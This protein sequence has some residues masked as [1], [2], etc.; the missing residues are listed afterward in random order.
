MNRPSCIPSQVLGTALA[1]SMGLFGCVG[2]YAPGA[3][4]EAPPSSTRVA[5]QRGCVD[6]AVTLAAEPTLPASS[7]LL[8]FTFGNRCDGLQTIDLSRVVVVGR[9]GAGDT[10]LAG[11]APRGQVHPGQL[12]AK[13]F[14]TELLRYDAPNGTAFERVC[15]DLRDVASGAD[16]TVGLQCLTPPG[17][18]RVLQVVN[19]DDPPFGKTW[20]RSGDDLRFFTSFGVSTHTIRTSS[21]K[22]S[23]KSIGAFGTDALG[24]TLNAV[25]FDLRASFFVTRAI[26]VGGEFDLGLGGADSVVLHTL[27]SVTTVAGPAVHT[28]VGG[29]VGYET[30]RLGAFS[31]RGE[32]FLGGRAIGLDIREQYDCNHDGCASLLGGK[33][34]V[35][36]RVA[37]DMW[38]TPQLTFGGWVQA[39]VAHPG[40]FSAGIGL[41]A[42]W[43]NFDAR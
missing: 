38:A 19:P 15:V 31:A 34:M 11:R 7:A 23:E 37:V 16:D 14:G 40:D 30:P 8:W 9:S 21:L 6:V 43:R 20:E 17:D 25:T 27:P 18:P 39:D 5:K 22:L 35:A 4:L 2:A 42:H 29:H 36:P 28:V 32:L 26:Y 41:S 12:D 1:T 3:M 10:P 13:G 24:P 33:W